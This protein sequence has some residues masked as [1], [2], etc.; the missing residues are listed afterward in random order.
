MRQQRHH[1]QP[2][3]AA[4]GGARNLE[5]P[6]LGSGVV[7]G[8]HRAQQT[9]L[10]GAVGLFALEVVPLDGAAPAV[11]SHDRHR[12]ARARHFAAG[13]RQGLR[14]RVTPGVD[15]APLARAQQRAVAAVGR[16][17]PQRLWQRRLWQRLAAFRG[18]RGVHE[19]SR[20][21]DPLDLQRVG[22]EDLAQPVADEVDHALKIQP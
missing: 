10:V 9:H 2:L 6:R 15:D 1:D 5:A 21:V 14:L 7:D 20:R 18:V 12:D 11:G 3:V 16:P 22:G 4:A 17:P 19:I 8:G 13:G